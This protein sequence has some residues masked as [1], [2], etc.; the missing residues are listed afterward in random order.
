MLLP[1]VLLSAIVGA[2]VGMALIVGRRH[3]RGTP[4][5]F[6]PFLAAAGWVA[7]MW[8]PQLVQGYFSLYG[9]P[10]R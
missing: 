9:A 7:L 3:Q 1:I 2:L 6:G 8:G 5:P 4:I 10:G